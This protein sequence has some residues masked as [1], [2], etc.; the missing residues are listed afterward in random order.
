[1]TKDVEGAEIVFG[2]VLEFE[3]QKVTVVGKGAAAQFDDKS[4]SEV[5]YMHVTESIITDK[6]LVTLTNANN[7]RITLEHLCLAKERNE[8]LVGGRLDEELQRVAIVIDP[9]QR[10]NDRLEN[11]A[12]GD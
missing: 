4:R 5:G 8:W 9:L 1:V 10:V 6:A 3:S 7:R 11:R 12:P 2:A